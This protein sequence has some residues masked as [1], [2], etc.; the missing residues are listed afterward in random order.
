MPTSTKLCI[1]GSLC[2]FLGN[3]IGVWKGHRW[4]MD[5]LDRSVKAHEIIFVRTNV[6]FESNAP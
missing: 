5:A 2:F 1:V 6:T 4:T 3:L